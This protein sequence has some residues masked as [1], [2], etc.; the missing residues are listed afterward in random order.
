MFAM[1][2]SVEAGGQLQRSRTANPQVSVPVASITARS[3][4]GSCSQYFRVP[5]VRSDV[6]TPSP[7]A[8]HPYCTG[9]ASASGL[10][11]LA[12]SRA[13][14]C[15]WVW[16]GGDHTQQQPTW[17][18]FNAQPNQVDRGTGRG[19]DHRRRRGRRSEPQ[20]AAIRESGC[21]TAPSSFSAGPGRCRRRGRASPSF[22]GGRVVSLRARSLSNRMSLPPVRVALLPL[23]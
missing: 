22:A 11:R 18:E 3:W 20:T 17:R 15:C 6:S 16:L 7:H 13:R 9:R 23:I 5:T 1:W 10:V 8:P 14:C 4:P 2:R 19:H 12:S 21:H